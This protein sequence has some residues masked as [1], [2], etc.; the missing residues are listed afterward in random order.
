MGLP[1]QK[2]RI[3]QDGLKVKM[4]PKKVVEKKMDSDIIKSGAI[5]GARNPLGEAAKE[6]AK[7][8]YGLVRTMKTDVKK[9]A[10]VSGFSED[11][12]QSV[13]NFI[14]LQKHDLGNGQLE[15]FEPDFMMAESWRRLQAGMPEPHDFTMLKHELMEQRLMRNGMSQDEAHKIT[16]KT[17]N[18]GKEAQAF[19]DKIREY[20]K[21]K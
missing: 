12:I 19:Y 1:M 15:Y 21:D 9:I 11:E 5:S 6:H 14:F 20:K 7:K 18:Y 10:A 8:Y 13:K 3:Y 2:E 16:S 17:Y 4:E